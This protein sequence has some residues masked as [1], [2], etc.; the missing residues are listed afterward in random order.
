MIACR[1]DFFL[2]KKK[3]WSK[4]REKK[5]TFSEKVLDD[6]TPSFQVQTMTRD[7]SIVRQTVPK[8]NHHVKHSTNVCFTTD[9]LIRSAYS[10]KC[11]KRF[12]GW[13]GCCCVFAG[14]SEWRLTSVKK[15]TK[16]CSRKWST[17]LRISIQHRFPSWDT[18]YLFVTGTSLI[19]SRSIFCLCSSRF[20][21]GVCLKEII[22]Q[23]INSE[24]LLWCNSC[25][26]VW[27]DTS[28]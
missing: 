4:K 3:L 9:Y 19:S 17:S 12:L 14:G 28:S 21:P 25:V 11:T 6:D 8:G 24:Y 5:E 15:N 22:H 27:K 26:I 10:K 2:K 23:S 13:N 1:F 16:N 7:M 18:D 20:E